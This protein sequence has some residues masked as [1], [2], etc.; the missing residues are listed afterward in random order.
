MCKLLSTY[1][2]CSACT[3]L[4]ICIYYV[5]TLDTAY[6]FDKHVQTSSDRYLLYWFN[7]FRETCAILVSYCR[8]L[9]LPIDA[10]FFHQ[11]VQRNWYNRLLA[12]QYVDHRSCQSIPIVGCNIHWLGKV[13]IDTYR[14]QQQASYWNRILSIAYWPGTFCVGRAMHSSIDA[15]FDVRRV[16]IHSVF[17][18]YNTYQ[19]LNV[20]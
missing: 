9:R 17:I 3:L 1:P 5:S 10:Y 13:Q 8:Y 12:E 16:C 14:D 19:V 4:C 18:S 11:Y 15:I 20:S 7:S 6:L 2:A